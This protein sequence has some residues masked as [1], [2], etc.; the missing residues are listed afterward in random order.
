MILALIAFV[1]LGLDKASITEKD[2]KFTNELVE[3]YNKKPV[4]SIT[5]ENLTDII[6]DGLFSTHKEGAKCLNC[7]IVF[8]WSVAVYTELLL[9]D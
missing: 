8:D 9:V 3:K 4:S 6:T 1:F 2:I 7:F 5:P